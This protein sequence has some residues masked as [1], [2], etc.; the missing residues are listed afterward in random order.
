LVLKISYQGRSILLGGDATTEETWPAIHASTALGHIDVLKAS[1]HGRKTGYHQPSVEKLSPCLTI[2][3][4]GEKEHD[5]TE[6]YRRYSD[7]TVSLRK[8]GDIQ[9]T[10]ADN[11]EMSCSLNTP[12]H[13]KSRRA[14]VPPLARFAV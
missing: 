9:I 5:A 3:S 8:A 13:W 12:D 7:Y 14:I 1:H 2:T 6:S 4:V 11:G 10:I